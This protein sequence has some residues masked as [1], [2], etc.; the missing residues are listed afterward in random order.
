M[1]SKLGVASDV[2]KLTH[3][4]QDGQGR[5]MP[6]GKTGQAA[7]LFLMAP[8]IAVSTAPATPDHRRVIEFRRLEE[9]GHAAREGERR[10]AGSSW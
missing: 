5:A 1:R 8:T 9:K 4:A 2:C 7:D 10:N 3:G 6:I